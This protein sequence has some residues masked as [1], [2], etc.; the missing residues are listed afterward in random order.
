MTVRVSSCAE[1]ELIDAVE[2]YNHQQGGLGY[3]FARE[4]QKTF[5]RIEQYP[6]VFS[7]FSKYT[8]RG[9]VDRFPYGVL[10]VEED[11]TILIL[12][13]M[14]LHKDPEHW[15]KRLGESR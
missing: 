14:N 5:K 8:R 11:E 13:I 12:N 4:V 7:P 2:Y 6:N 9:L 10:Y 1:Q 3:V 15:R